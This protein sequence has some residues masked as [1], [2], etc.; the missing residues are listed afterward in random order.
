MSEGIKSKKD[1]VVRKLRECCKQVEVM[2]E[3]PAYCPEFHQWRQETEALVGRIFGEG[4][5]QIRDFKAIYYNPVLLSC[6]TG[7][8]DFEAAYRE[9]LE[10]ARKMIVSW[11]DS[12][13][14]EPQE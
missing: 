3:K 4:S 6:R 13:G 1:E 10:Q 8:A 5:D 2:K 9:G 11:I 7:D 14:C 12:L